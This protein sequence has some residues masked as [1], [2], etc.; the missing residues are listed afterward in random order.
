MYDHCCS[1]FGR[2]YFC[3]QGKDGRDGIPGRD[4]QPGRD[5]T[6]Y[7]SLGVLRGVINETVQRGMHT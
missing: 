2:L 4:G 3:S 5:G 6:D 1:D 7:N